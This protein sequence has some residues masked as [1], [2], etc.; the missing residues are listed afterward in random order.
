M[1]HI[2]NMTLMAPKDEAE[3]QRMLATCLALDGPAAVRYPRGV[4]VGTPLLDDP[5][6]F[7]LGEA[8]LLKDGSDIAVLAVGSRV[9]PALEA[10]RELGRQE[11]LSVAVLNAR[12]VK[13]LA[14]AQILEL[15]RKT[16]RLLLVEENILA[17]GFGSAVLELLAD[18]GALGGLEV[19]RVGLKDCFVEHGG[20]RELRAKHGIDK[21]GIAKVLADMAGLRTHDS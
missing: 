15:A 14:E 19:R 8:E 20:Q 2:P 10:A 5:E 12:F 1:R 11:G 18:N 9:Y 16:G 7:D 21:H 6:P 17:G 4:G 13:P 3:L